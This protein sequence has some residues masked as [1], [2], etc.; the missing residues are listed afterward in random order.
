MV[1]K[2]FKCISWTFFTKLLWTLSEAIKNLSLSFY[3]FVHVYV[4]WK[5]FKGFVVFVFLMAKHCCSLKEMK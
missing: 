4:L 5:V 2:Q 1:E 3:F